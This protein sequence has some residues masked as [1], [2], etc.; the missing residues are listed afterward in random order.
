MEY[1]EELSWTGERLVPQLKD[2]HGVTEHLHRY[3][4]AMQ[5]ATKKTV[6]DIACGEGYGS[7][8]LATVADRVYGVDIDLSSVLHAQKKYAQSHGGK[9]H[10]IQGSA[11]QIPDNIGKVDLIVS[12][13]T[14]EHLEAQEAMLAQFRDHLQPDG[15]LIISTPEKEL[16][17]QRDPHNTFHVKELN[18]AAFQQLIHAYFPHAH[19]YQQRFVFGSAITPLQPDTPLQ[20]FQFFSGDYNE[21]VQGTGNDSFYHQPYFNVAVCSMLPHSLPGSIGSLFEAANLLNAMEA[22]YQK[23]I[24]SL[25]LWKQQVLHDPFYRLW[26]KIKTRLL[27]K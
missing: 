14:L 16:Y 3:A 13:E 26:Q 19:F 18:L 23:Q 17:Q 12:F 8:L 22:N 9:L 11:T 20:G 25:Q 27:F 15:M 1:Q 5:F 2:M 4:L 21:I 24:Q 6:L 10:Y 7:N